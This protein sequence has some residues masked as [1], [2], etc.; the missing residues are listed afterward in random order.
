[1]DFKLIT[2][3][4]L[5][6]IERTSIPKVTSKDY[7]MGWWST[8]IGWMIS[9]EQSRALKDLYL[10]VEKIFEKNNGG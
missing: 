9:E 7:P 1:M 10:R 5:M 6:E 3:K 8:N 2:E 4:V